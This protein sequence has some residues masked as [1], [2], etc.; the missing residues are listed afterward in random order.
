[1]TRNLYLGVDLAR[2]FQVRS[3]ADVRRVAGRMVAD[4]ERRPFPAR[5]AAIAEEVE[6]TRPDVVGVQEAA[7]V[8]VQ[9]PSDFVVDPGPNASR[10]AIDFLEVLSEALA[11][12]GLD[13]EV[14]ASVVTSD[15]EVPAD[16]EGRTVD[17]RLTDR[18][19]LLVR[20]GVEVGETRTGTFE[21]GFG[22]SV[23]GYAATIDRGYATVA[24]SVDDIR[25]TVATTHLES[26]DATVR[27]QQARELLD[28][29]PSGG[30]SYSRAT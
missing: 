12:R 6:S 25:A 4:V 29:L 20:E 1:M 14:A 30:R 15:V 23:D 9:E 7:L 21:A 10:V 24:V 28:V 18:D 13:Y 17:V 26:A 11:A 5:A 22:V 16:V 8:R 2:L 19:A 3:V 27:Q